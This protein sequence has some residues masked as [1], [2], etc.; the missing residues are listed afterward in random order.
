MLN[1][2]T[3]WLVE[4]F[5]QIKKKILTPKLIKG[6]ITIQ[7]SGI[8]YEISNEGDPCVTPKFFQKEEKTTYTYIYM[9]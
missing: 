8:L 3:V 9:I 4:T 1:V 5:S 6:K 7:K 2:L